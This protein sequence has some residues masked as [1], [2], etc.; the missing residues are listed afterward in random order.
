M[1]RLRRVESRAGRIGLGLGAFVLLWLVAA[2]P[3]VGILGSS[4]IVWGED[5]QF[6]RVDIPGSEVLN[7]PAKTID[8]DVALALPGRGNATPDLRLPNDLSLSVTPVDGSAEP[9]ITENIGSTQN[10]NTDEQDTQRL[11]WHLKVPEGGDYRVTAGGDFSGYGLNPQLWFGDE[12]PIPGRLVPLYAALLTLLGF[13]VFFGWK[14]LR[15]GRRVDE[16]HSTAD[17]PV[18]SLQ[19]DKRT[20]DSLA[21]LGEQHARGGF[22][23]EEYTAAK[24]AL[25]NG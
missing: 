18:P 16:P 2:L 1:K 20:A 7:L 4:N 19:I 3:I 17:E 5:N 21:E 12:P 24:Q 25:L 8:V 22:T 10:A 14:R 9:T 13:G 6:G 15:S 11:V 23:D